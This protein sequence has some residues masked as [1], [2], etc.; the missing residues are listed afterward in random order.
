MAEGEGE[1]EQEAEGKRQGERIGYCREQAGEISRIIFYTFRRIFVEAA[2]E[3]AQV[4]ERAG[5][6]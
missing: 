6:E 1:G 4:S 2:D 3:A 5:C